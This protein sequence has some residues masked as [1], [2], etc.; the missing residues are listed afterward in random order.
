MGWFWFVY[1]LEF[2]ALRPET[3]DR[4]VICTMSHK[5]LARDGKPDLAY[6]FTPGEQGPAVVFLGGYASDMEGTK[7][8]YLEAQCRA[9]GQ[10][11]L[12]LDYSGHGASGGAFKDGTIGSWLAD[13]LDVIDAIIGV[14]H[15]V[16]VVGSSMGGW[17]AL[18]AL[19]VRSEQVAGVVGIAAAPDFSRDVA[20]KMTEAQRAML[21]EQGYAEQPNDYSDVPYI[22]TKKLMEDAEECMLLDKQHAI[23]AP[24][25][26]I[27]GKQ[28]ADVHWE[29]AEA[30]K[31]AFGDTVEIVYIDDADHR[32]SRDQDLAI[33]DKAVQKISV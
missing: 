25:I 23:S 1:P 30:I 2:R 16:I 26:L 8:T 24:V 12:R 17:I 28:D 4:K 6:H 3:Q 14:D 13:V 33:I 18:L 5:T 20:A 29:K 21:E 31:T 11:Y 10:S 27:Q 9:R 15:P 32:V 22:F 19:L 7:A